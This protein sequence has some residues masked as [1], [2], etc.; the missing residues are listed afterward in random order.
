MKYQ[1][2]GLADEIEKLEEL[3][4]YIKNNQDG[5]ISY[6]DREGIE[7]PSPPKGLEY[8]TLGTIEKN[9]DIFAKRMKGGKSWSKQE[10]LI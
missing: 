10:P 8:R 1:S 2:D 6:K 5:I 4:R 9:V 7:I 3:E